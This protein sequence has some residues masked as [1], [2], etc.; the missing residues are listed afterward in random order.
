MT[1]APA[2]VQDGGMPA[3]TGSSKNTAPSEDSAPLVSATELA[4][5]LDGPEASAVRL[6]DVRYRLDKPD[7][8]DDYRA[9][10][11]PGAVY[12]PLDEEL[13]THGAPDE[14]R[15]PMPMHD[16]LQRAVTRWGVDDGDL[17]VVYDGG[18]T[19]ASGRAWWLLRG[20][21]LDVRVLDGG[22]P[23]WVAAGLRLDTDDV[24]ESPGDAVIGPLP[25]GLTT[26]EASAFPD[27]GVL[28]DVRAAE[29]YRGETEPFDPI[30]GHVPGAVNLPATAFF[31]D[32]GTFRAVDE[33][34]AAFDGVGATA[35]ARVATY[36]G[37]GIT[38]AQAAL[39]AAV[40]GREVEVYPGSWS[41]WSNT[42]GMPVATGPEPL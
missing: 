29:R 12:V 3:D 14:G 7:G 9:G 34:A 27:G 10:H 39:A 26:A 2:A 41:A 33:I 18:S 16:T 5:L 42:P 19:L 38:A 8:S 15:H 28:V 1:L 25:S 4:A 13:T 24:V 37:S 17:V 20:V 21:G 32:D 40:A 31:A 23:A 35:D 22:L 36:C 11:I 30:A 6:L